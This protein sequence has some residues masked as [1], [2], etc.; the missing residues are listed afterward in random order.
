MPS[1]RL[2]LD[3]AVTTVPAASSTLIGRHW[4]CLGRLAHTRIPLYWLEIR[5]LGER[6]AWRTLAP[7]DQ[8]RGSGAAIGEGWR[9]LT[10]DARLRWDDDAWVQ[11]VGEEA[12]QLALWDEGSGEL[13]DGEAL[14]AL[15]E[16]R[17]GRVMPL[18][19]DGDPHAD[20]PDGALVPD[21]R[22]T[23]RLLRPDAPLATDLRG[24]SVTDPQLE[25]DV[26]LAALEL[27][28]SVGGRSVTVHGSAV[29]SIVPYAIARRDHRGLDG[30]WLTL[31]EAWQWWVDIGGL[32]TS[33]PDRLG[34]ERGKVRT[35]L[36]RAGVRDLD[37]LFE[38]KRS[39]VETATRLN[40]RS[41][42]VNVHE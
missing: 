41:A 26:D 34:W 19:A 28:L 27:T 20:L 9:A 39:A 13:R 40:V 17:D 12:P 8:T 35:Q 14:D 5:W 18:S 21:G 31:H 36:A 1:L 11:L 29:R 15:L 37:Q 30:G 24:F 23:W 3:G 16:A 33:A 42:Q 22:R 32:A 10:A 25:L 4:S 7:N 2:S 6:W 38:T